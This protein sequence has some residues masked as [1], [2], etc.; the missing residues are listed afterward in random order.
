[1]LENVTVRW[2]YSTASRSF[3]PTGSTHVD[4]RLLQIDHVCS[5]C[6]SVH[7]YDDDAESYYTDIFSNPPRL[8]IMPL[9]DR[10]DSGV[11]QLPSPPQHPPLLRHRESSYL[12]GTADKSRKVRDKIQSDEYDRCH[13]AELKRFVVDRGLEDPFPQGLTLKLYYLK[14]LAQADREW[15]FRFLDLPAELRVRIYRNLLVGK[16]A[17]KF[18]RHFV[19]IH[20]AILRVCKLVLAEAEDILYSENDFEVLCSLSDTNDGH[21]SHHVLVGSND[22]GHGSGEY[23]TLPFCIDQYPDMFR[24]IRLLTVS[25]QYHMMP[26][27]SEKR[28]LSLLN[29]TLCGL[30]SF[31]MDKHRL[32]RLTLAVE[33]DNHDELDEL[34]YRKLLY[35]LRRLRNIPELSVSGHI[36]NTLVKQLRRDLSSNEPAFNTVRLWQYLSSQTEDHLDLM[37]E[38]HGADENE[39]NEDRMGMQCL[40]HIEAPFYD[41]DAVASDGLTSTRQEERTLAKLHKL[42]KSL[43]RTNLTKITTMAER[44]IEKRRDLQCYEAGTDDGRLE[45]AARICDEVSEDEDLERT[46]TCE[47]SSDEGSTPFVDDD[48]RME[49]DS[50]KDDGGG[51]PTNDDQRNGR[52][53]PIQHPT[54]PEILDGDLA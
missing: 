36:P 39:D 51:S 10:T 4:D 14:L 6:G 30:S 12:P 11:M 17:N 44:I 34:H 31:L 15:S 42:R 41:V 18:N 54:Q 9:D 29:H 38:V 2:E 49:L 26:E 13:P 50:A 37:L 35:P 16:W 3:V 40:D 23:T 43:D 8:R 27:A 19:N 28:G 1:M 22:P 25:I 21:V 45:E 20:P 7:A 46:S 52:T 5:E 32:Q 24:R 48:D 33:I 53:T 47:W